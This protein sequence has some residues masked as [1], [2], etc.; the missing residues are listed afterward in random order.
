MMVYSKRSQCACFMQNR[1]MSAVPG[2]IWMLVCKASYRALAPCSSTSCETVHYSTSRQGSLFCA[3][4]LAAVFKNESCASVI[5]GKRMELRVVWVLK[6][7]WKTNKINIGKIYTRTFMQ[8]VC[9]T[10]RTISLIYRNIRNLSYFLV[11]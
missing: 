6:Q 2:C 5:F 1:V 7:V 10:V 8:V 3:N 4:R 11:I 9:C